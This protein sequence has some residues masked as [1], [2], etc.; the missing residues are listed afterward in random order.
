M[1]KKA[2][3]NFDCKVKILN[4]NFIS[5]L[6]LLTNGLCFI[7]DDLI[8]LN[9]FWYICIHFL[10]KK[11]LHSDIIYTGKNTAVYRHTGIQL[12]SVYKLNAAAFSSKTKKCEEHGKS[13]RGKKVPWYMMS[14]TSVICTGVFYLFY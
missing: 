8:L 3:F 12:P 5:I 4:Q 10:L 9:S 11:I 13:P 6:F 1:W 14:E 2:G 7:F